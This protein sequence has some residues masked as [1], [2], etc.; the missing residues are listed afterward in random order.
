ME[1]RRFG[2]LLHKLWY[3]LWSFHINVLNLSIT[4]EIFD[5]KQFKLGAL[6]QINNIYDHAL[7]TAKKQFF[8]LIVLVKSTIITVKPRLLEVP[9]TAGILSNNR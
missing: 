9:G 7:V 3:Q 1:N 2:I 5:L 8:M 4:I 6:S